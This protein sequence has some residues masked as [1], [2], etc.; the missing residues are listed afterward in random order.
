[1]E[2]PAALNLLLIFRFLIFKSK[3]DFTGGDSSTV[4]TV[5]KYPAEEPCDV[6]RGEWTGVLKR[7][8]GVSAAMYGARSVTY[9]VSMVVLYF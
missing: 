3:I 6:M 9:M 1:M 2:E 5:P 7:V 4:V 8:L